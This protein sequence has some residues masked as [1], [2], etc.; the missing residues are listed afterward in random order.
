M[1]KLFVPQ[2]SDYM[3]ETASNENFFCQNQSLETNKTSSEFFGFV[4][5]MDFVEVGIYLLIKVTK[6]CL[7]LFFLAQIF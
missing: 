7:P 5:V 6:K 3:L 2:S 1:Y 4:T